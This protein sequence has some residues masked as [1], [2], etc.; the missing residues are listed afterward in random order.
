MLVTTV[1]EYEEYKGWENLL[2]NKA[3]ETKQTEEDGSWNKAL[4]VQIGDARLRIV[5]PTVDGK[6]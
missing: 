1:V 5:G 6:S 4:N 3:V 2:G